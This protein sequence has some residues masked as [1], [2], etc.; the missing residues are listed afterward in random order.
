MDEALAHLDAEYCG[1]EEYLTGTAGMR[2]QDLEA[3]RAR[4]LDRSSA[5]QPITCPG[6]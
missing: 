5:V 2:K 3:L 6:R 4:L 1:V